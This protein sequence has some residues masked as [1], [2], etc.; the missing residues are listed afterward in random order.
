MNLCITW[1]CLN[2]KTTMGLCDK[3]LSHYRDS[4]GRD[5]GYRDENSRKTVVE[6]EADTGRTK[7][8]QNASVWF[9]YSYLPG[10]DLKSRLQYGGSGSAYY[11]YEP[12]R[13]LLTQVRNYINGGVVSQYDYVNDAIG[14][15]T[16]IS[17]SGSRMTESRTDAYG[18][19]DRNELTNAVKNATL[20][21]YAYQYDD[22][23]NRLSSLDLGTNRTYTANALNQ[24][25][26]VGRDD[27]I[28]PHEEF[29]P[30][31]DLDGNQTLVRTATGDWT[32]AYNAENRP[33]SWTCG[34][35][36]IVMLFD[37]MGRR[38]EYVETV[39][40]DSGES[41]VT[42]T[43]RH[44]RFVYEITA[45][46]AGRAHWALQAERTE[47][48][49]EVPREPSYLCVQRLN[50]RSGNAIELSFAWDPTE[51]VATRP[52]VLQRQGGWNFFY[53]HDMRPRRRRRVARRSVATEPRS[54]RKRPR[55]KN[56]SD[57]VSF[58]QARGVPAHYEYAPFGAVTAATTNTAFT[59]FNVVGTNP[60]RFSSEY[61]DDTLGM[62][63]YNYRHYNPMDG[64]W[65]QRD[66]KEPMQTL[67]AFVANECL[68]KTDRLGLEFLVE[69]HNP[70]EVP[71]KGWSTKE[72]TAETIM[73]KIIDITIVPTANGCP[74]G[75]YKFAVVFPKIQINIYYIDEYARIQSY[76]DEMEHVNC[77]RQ[78][79]DSLMAIG[80]DA[81]KMSCMSA[82]NINKSI[83]TFIL[84]QEKACEVC[85]ECNQ[86]LDAR[87]SHGH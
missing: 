15:R 40:D 75:C 36:N 50:A 48:S 21:E 46:Q 58:Q 29:S 61:S 69:H 53:T 4:Y 23:G 45:A 19:N 16:E 1:N 20:N 5:L 77:Y 55:N 47:R 63:Y 42:T 35:T 31:Y 84:R 38:V 7:R 83:D 39:T 73:N 27:P 34:A 51:P 43:N 54:G 60:Y 10:T 32:V 33:V 6:Y 87:G 74:E 2:D 26:L 59:A 72:S 24:Y 30:Q 3:M 68:G 52:L 71:E 11:T 85:D 57:V 49:D 80:E 12:N 64:R 86:K 9:T 14:R 67:L 18:Y 13:D 79:H 22:I 81:L 28:A 25:T 76:P 62:V 44:H 41:T 82:E 8:I 65:L 78:W 37:R 70:A 17:R 66:P 56:V